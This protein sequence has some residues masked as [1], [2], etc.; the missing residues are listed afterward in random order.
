MP[1]VSAGH[2][3]RCLAN[4]ST[5]FMIITL[6]K[7][8]GEPA[9]WKQRT[10]ECLPWRVMQGLQRNVIGMAFCCKKGGGQM[11]EQLPPPRLHTASGTATP[12]LPRWLRDT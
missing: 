6:K 10:T 2:E 9:N 1:V 3:L 5:V 11:W 12:G 4:I 8:P 7:C